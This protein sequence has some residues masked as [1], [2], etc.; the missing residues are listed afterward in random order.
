MK[1][2]GLMVSEKNI[3]SYY[4]PMGATDPP[5]VAN[6]NPRG[7]V[8]RIYVEYH[9]KLLHTKYENSGPHGFR[10]E[11]F[12]IISLCNVAKLSDFNRIVVK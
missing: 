2:L 12:P 7:M 1:V 8:C 9:L 10:E 3:F 11:V 5:G 4:K 6:F